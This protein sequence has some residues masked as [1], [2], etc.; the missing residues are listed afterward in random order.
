MIQQMMMNKM[1]KEAI[2]ICSNVMSKTNSYH[3]R[4]PNMLDKELF[5]SVVCD[6]LGMKDVQFTDEQRQAIQI[7]CLSIE[8]VCYFL[9]LEIG[10]LSGSMILRS[11]QFTAMVDKYLYSHGI[12][13]CSSE[14]KLS[15]YKKLQLD[16]CYKS[17]PEIFQ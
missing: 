1:N 3:E 17:H 4:Q 16:E 6:I 8:G 5:Y 11:A 13:P 15:Y 10:F 14:V 9:G 2:K 12:K 7:Y